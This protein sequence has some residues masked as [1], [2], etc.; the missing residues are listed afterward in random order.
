VQRLAKDGDLA[1]EQSGSYGGQS[2]DLYTLRTFR[3]TYQHLHQFIFTL[4][5]PSAYGDASEVSR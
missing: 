5:N 1:V 4:R 3:D 2:H